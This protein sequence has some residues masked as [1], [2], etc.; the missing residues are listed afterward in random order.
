ME[1]KN[2]KWMLSGALAASM[3]LGGQS[4]QAAE[5]VIEAIPQIVGVESREM[6]GGSR[7]KFGGCFASFPSG[8]I[9]VSGCNSAYVTFACDGS[10]SISKSQAKLSYDNATLAYVLDTNVKIRITD[11]IKLDGFCTAINAQVAR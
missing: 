3:A 9:T 4:T 6:D 7:R 10:S 1:L 2:A 5:Q 11:Q 8:T